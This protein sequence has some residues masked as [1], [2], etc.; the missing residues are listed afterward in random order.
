MN[1]PLTRF[2]LDGHGKRREHIT[3]PA[4]SG[5]GQAATRWRCGWRTIWWLESVCW[6]CL[7]EGAVTPGV[8]KGYARIHRE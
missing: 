1:K 4:C 5:S 8:A 3:C 2:V 7:G 6:W